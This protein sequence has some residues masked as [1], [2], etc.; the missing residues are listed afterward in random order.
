MTWDNPTVADNVGLHKI[1]F[2]GTQRNNTKFTSGSYMLGYIAT[3]FEGNVAVCQ[4]KVS[5]W[6]EG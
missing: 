2:L 4:F 5:I 6:E 3:D 1:D